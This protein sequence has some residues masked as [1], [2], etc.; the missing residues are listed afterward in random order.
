MPLF[1]VSF[2]E[3][4][5][6]CARGKVTPP[7]SNQPFFLLPRE[8]LDGPLPFHRRSPVRLGL[9]IDQLYREPAAGVT[10][11]GASVV[12]LHSP[13]RIC[14]PAGVE[15]SIPAF[16]DVAIKCHRDYFRFLREPTSIRSHTEGNSDRSGFSP[17]NHFAERRSANQRS[18]PA[19]A[20]SMLP[21]RPS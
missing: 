14:R 7:L 15:G 10:R 9:K 21:D 16:K 12:L 19:K 2:R 11:P 8:A 20:C 1:A 17:S 6:M 5:S 13:L 4:H 18:R 3:P